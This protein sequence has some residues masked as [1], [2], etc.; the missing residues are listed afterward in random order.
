MASNQEISRKRKINGQDFPSPRLFPQSPQ[1]EKEDSEN[2]LLALSLSSFPHQ[3]SCKPTTSQ[4]Q[5]PPPQTQPPSLWQSLPWPQP[6]VASPQIS[7]AAPLSF[8]TNPPA[9]MIPSETVSSQ[10]TSGAARTGTAGGG[11]SRGRARR[12]SNSQ[13]S[14]REGKSEMVQP[15]Y[16]WATNRRATVYSL[17]YLLSKQ[18]HSISGDVQCKRCERQYSMEYDLRQKFIEIGTFIA[19]NKSLMHDRAPKI[20]MN[21]TLPTCRFC[22][23]E[24]SVK[25]II[26]DKKK[27]INWLFLLLGQLLGCCALEQLKYFCKHTK[28][29]RTG[30]KDRVLYLTYL[31][32]CKQ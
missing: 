8:F 25:P 22:E 13:Y 21:P 27:S 1:Q 30:A 15:Q 9:I 23:Q 10:F 7:P 5:P 29:H 31:G 16:P 24:N 18:I 14:S 2:D 17:S 26:A 6:P 11:P 28:N 19:E 4:H 12:S 32:L 20:W 3:S